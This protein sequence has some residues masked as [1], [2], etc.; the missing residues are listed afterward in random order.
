[1]PLHD[2]H[3]EVIVRQMLGKVTVIDSGDTEMLPGEIID[4]NRF[5]RI[6]RQAVSEGKKPASARQEV[7]GMTRASLAAQSWLSAASFQE[8]T[9]VLTQ[10]ALDRRSD[11]LVGLK[12]NVIIGKLIPAGTGLSAYRNIEVDGTEK[13]KEER[14]PNRIWGQEA[15]VEE[16]APVATLSFSM[17]EDSADSSSEPV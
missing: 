15:L 11:P 13:A 12:E 9:R 17:E 7:M 2:K 4:R 5:T 1:V 6:N 8:T 16:A 10:A 14:Y 3:L